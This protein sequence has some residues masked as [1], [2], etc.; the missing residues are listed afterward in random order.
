MRKPAT[1]TAAPLLITVLC[2][3]TLALQPLKAAAE[4]ELSARQLLVELV[5]ASRA[6]RPAILDQI[7]DTG[8]PVVGTFYEAWRLGRISEEENSARILLQ[9][10]DG[11][12]QDLLSGE[13]A[14]PAGALKTNRASRAIRKDMKRLV[15]ILDLSSPDPEKRIQ[16]AEKL[17]MSQNAEY[18]PELRKRAE[19]QSDSRTQKAFREAI[20]ISQ[21]ANGTHEE[22]LSAIRTL[23]ELKSFPARDFITA[24]DNTYREEKREGAGEIASA[25]R[26]A[27]ERIDQHQKLV[28]FAGT[29][30]RG[31]SLG[32]VLLLVAYGLAITFGQMGV[33]NMAHGEFIAIGG[34]TTYLIQNHFAATYGLGTAA[35]GNYFLISLPCAFLT[36]AL[37][38]ALLEKSMIR[39]LYSRPLES[40]LATWGLSMII[41]QAF[42]LKFG[43]ANVSVSSPEWLRGNLEL[44]GIA[45][46]YNRLFLIVFALLVIGGTWLLMN[47]TNWGL[48]VRATM[49]NRQMASNLGV[50]S[51]RVNMLTFAFGSG[52]AGLAG[53]FISQ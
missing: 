12:Y 48:H 18:L 52:L 14:T 19:H 20:A 35:F 7:A 38:G 36:A 28:E 50:P 40:L 17:G 13:S 45:M 3:L 51:G 27:L 24:V 46:S 32:S 31:L 42:R 39:F 43:A 10:P 29:L 25:A 37:A 16:A 23:G 4:E 49:Q 34:Y 6:D 1:A 33:I 22:I 21:L 8:Q 2:L 5:N 30:F 47:K 9:N 26:K 53:A 44:F 11:S 15:D 41:Q